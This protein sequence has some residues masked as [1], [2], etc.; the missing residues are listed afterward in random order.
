M[1]TTTY[2]LN[3]PTDDISLFKALVKKFGWIAQ[4]QT[5]RTSC[6]LDEALKAADEE[7]LFETKDL[8]DLMKSLTK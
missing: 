1:A 3:I 8:D 6:R 7:T 2:T 5:N 4:K